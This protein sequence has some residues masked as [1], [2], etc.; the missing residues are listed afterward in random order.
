MYSRFPETIFGFGFPHSN[1]AKA[2][3]FISQ[4]ERKQICDFFQL[5]GGRPVEWGIK[6][7]ADGEWKGD[8]PHSHVGE[9]RVNNFLIRLRFVYFVFFFVD[10]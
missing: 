5:D 2:K 9:F 1:N 4:V 10:I 7:A 6:R 3:Q 8:S